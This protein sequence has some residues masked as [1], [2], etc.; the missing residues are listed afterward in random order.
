[1]PEC[2]CHGERNAEEKRDCRETFPRHTE[3]VRLIKS[4]GLS[5]SWEI[6]SVHAG[7][8]CHEEKN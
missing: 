7:V 4:Y 3:S 6:E 5:E 2:V 8:V 1:M